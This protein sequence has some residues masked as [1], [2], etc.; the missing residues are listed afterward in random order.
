MDIDE[1]LDEIDLEYKPTNSRDKS[2]RSF[3]EPS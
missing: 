3:V 2:R 1:L